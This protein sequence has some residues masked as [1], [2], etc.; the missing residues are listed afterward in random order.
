MS[1]E[2][3]KII[4]CIFLFIIW[5]LPCFY[6]KTFDET[7]VFFAVFVLSVA[8]IIRVKSEGIKL[9]II[10]VITIASS[11][12]NIKYLF[13]VFPVVLLICAHCFLSR[14]KQEEKKRE[15]IISAGTYATLSFIV[16]IGEIVYAF[17][18]YNNNEIHKIENIYKVLKIV[19]IFI[20][21]F[22]VLIIAS[23]SK[24]RSKKIANKKASEY[25]MIYIVSLAGLLV[26]V[27]MFYSLYSYEIQS[28][29]TEYVFWFLFLLIMSFN[30][31][32]FIETI[33]E[34]MKQVINNNI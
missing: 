17:V 30:D 19:I 26:S 14:E 9:L 32:P 5:L 12:Y 34:K 11:V 16:I 6:Q 7:Y 10:T 13:T 2:K 24:K 1:R 27:F 33:I 18:Q 4:S 15:K 21:A 28:I 31:D 3:N 25:T 23:A 22:T 29:R 8:A 20:V